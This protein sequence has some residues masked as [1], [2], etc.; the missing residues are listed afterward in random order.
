MVYR[1]K[2]NFSRRTEARE[3]Q[4]EKLLE[5]IEKRVG[6]EIREVLEESWK[7]FESSEHSLEED[8]LH[9]YDVVEQALDHYQEVEI[10]PPAELIIALGVHDC[11]R[12]FEGAPELKNF[13][14]RETYKQAHAWMS[15]QRARD[16]L[17][18]SQIEPDL[19]SRAL[20]R[21]V[22]H[23]ARWE[24]DQIQKV[25]VTI[26][27]RSFWRTYLKSYLGRIG[28]DRTP[29]QVKD[30]MRSKYTNLSDEDRE[31]VEGQVKEI[32]SPVLQRLFEELTREFAD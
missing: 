11:D 10:D 19:V 8:L 29:D 9:L 24:Y 25:F 21:I 15:A 7:V 12:F 31:W 4:K 26:D 23:H 6:K 16:I 14:N 13:P 5:L 30:K 28:K 1:E 2:E 27:E 3:R 20:A 18:K 22:V 32:D 17:I